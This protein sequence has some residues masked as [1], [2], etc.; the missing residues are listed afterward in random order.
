MTYKGIK[1]KYVSLNYK[2]G[3]SPLHLIRLADGR[4]ILLTTSETVKA[5]LAT[6]T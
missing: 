2:G 6:F 1:V 3:Y 4:G 5:G